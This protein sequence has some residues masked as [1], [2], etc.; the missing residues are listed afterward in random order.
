MSIDKYLNCGIKDLL[1]QFP[2]IGELVD[3]IKIN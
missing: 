3:E 2:K 1:M